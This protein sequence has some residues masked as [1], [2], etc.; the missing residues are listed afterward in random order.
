MCHAKTAVTPQAPCHSTPSRKA[1]FHKVLLRGLVN[2]LCRE[3]MRC[4]PGPAIAPRAKQVFYLRHVTRR[5]RGDA[6]F[7]HTIFT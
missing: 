1:T 2:D 6:Y 4:S 7:L 3:I 5:L